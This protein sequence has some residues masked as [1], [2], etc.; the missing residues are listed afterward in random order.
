MKIALTDDTPLTLYSPEYAN[1]WLL[2]MV[3]RWQTHAKNI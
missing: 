2:F 3:N 1:S